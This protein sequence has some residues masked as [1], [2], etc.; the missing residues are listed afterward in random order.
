MHAGATATVSNT[1]YLW[2]LAHAGATETLTHAG[3]DATELLFA[4]GPVSETLTHAG[5]DEKLCDAV[6]QRDTR[7]ALE[8]HASTSA[9][10]RCMQAQV[11]Q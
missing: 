2:R 4:R 5:A 6:P 9:T 8:M 3:A 1:V 7:R 10:M 11:P